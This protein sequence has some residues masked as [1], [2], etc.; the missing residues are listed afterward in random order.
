MAGLDTLTDGHHDDITGDSKERHIRLDRTGSSPGIDG[1]DD[2]RF[3]PQSRHI[4]VLVGFDLV[5]CFQAVKLCALCDGAFHFFRKRR[6][7][8]LSSAVGNSHLFRTQTNGGTGTVHGYVTAADY[9]YGLVLEVRHVIVTDAAQHFHCRHDTVGILS[10]DT[11]LFIR[12]GTDGNIDCIV[13][14][15]QLIIRNLTFAVADS[16]VQ[17]HFHSGGQNSVN[18]LL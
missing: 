7:I 6:H 14:F 13:F 18:V 17:F 9:D 5:R 16:G 15:V 8:G 2:L 11:D 12:M 10:L 3:Y 1:A 4:A